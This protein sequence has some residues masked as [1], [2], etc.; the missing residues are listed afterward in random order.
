MEFFY[1]TTTHHHFLS[2]FTICFFPHLS[3]NV[4]IILIFLVVYKQFSS[5]Y[6]HCFV[7]VFM[8][9]CRDSSTKPNWTCFSVFLTV[10]FN[11]Y[12]Y[13]YFLSHFLQ[14][15]TVF[16][17]LFHRFYPKDKTNLNVEL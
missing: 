12:C 2:S 3:S 13:S 7:L 10:I 16:L 6:V 15:V 14:Y 1:P 9:F 4:S 17:P 8:N 11:F 5:F